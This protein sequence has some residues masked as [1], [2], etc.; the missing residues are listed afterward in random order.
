MSPLTPYSP[1]LPV[2][3][4]GGGAWARE[5]GKGPLMS[6]SKSSKA[7]SGFMVSIVILFTP[8]LPI[9]HD[10]RTNSSIGMLHKWIRCSGPLC[11]LPGVMGKK[12]TSTNALIYCTG[13]PPRYCDGDTR[14]FQDIENISFTTIRIKKT[15]SSALNKIRNLTLPETA[16][17]LCWFLCSWGQNSCTHVKKKWVWG[18]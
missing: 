3:Q 6:T 10:G 9:T 5:V 11:V 13:L 15:E 14:S 2:F 4:P 1:G 17:D 18:E 8:P 7:K 12:P 16:C